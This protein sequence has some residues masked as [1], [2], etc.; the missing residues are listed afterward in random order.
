MPFFLL[1]AFMFALAFLG[2]RATRASYVVIAVTS[3]IAC[4]LALR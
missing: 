2:K 3:G 1:V 4:Y